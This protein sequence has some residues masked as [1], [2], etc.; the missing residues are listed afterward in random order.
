MTTQTTLA[1][2]ATYAAAYARL[3]DIAAR[4]RGPGTAATI[5]TLADD[6]RMARE[7]YGVCKARLDAIRAAIDAEIA[8]VQSTDATL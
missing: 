7:A 3:S 1:P 2:T 5:D 6:V 8:A 4:L